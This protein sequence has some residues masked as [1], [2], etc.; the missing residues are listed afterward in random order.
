MHTGRPII[1]A[2]R[3]LLFLACLSATVAARP[4]RRIVDR[5]MI[6]DVRSEQEHAYAGN[7]VSTGVAR[8]HSF[9][10][11]RGWM[12]YA[13]TVFDD[14]EVTVACT[15]LGSDAPQTF[16][17]IV[18][19]QVVASHTFR[20]REQATVEFRVPVELTKGRTNLIVMLRATNGLTPALV[21]LRT[22]QDHN[23]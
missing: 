15:F 7:E 12:R 16:D 1:V 4:D 13:L 19:N 9:R 5:V 14:T 17:L 10:Q 11:A 23:E 2:T 3:R 20:S 6:G 8:G 21:E 22:I 18:E